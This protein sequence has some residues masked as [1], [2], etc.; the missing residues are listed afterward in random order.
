MKIVLLL[1][2]F[3]TAL[4]FT[5]LGEDVK[6][7]QKMSDSG[8]VRYAESEST[9]IRPA[10]SAEGKIIGK[11]FVSKSGGTAAR[12]TKGLYGKSSSRLTKSGSIDKKAIV[13]IVKVPGKYPLPQSRP[14]MRQKN[15]AIVP[16]VLPVLLGTTVD[17]PNEDEIYHNIFSLSDTK[18]FDLGRY[19][20]GKSKSVTFNTLGTVKVFCDIHSQMGGVIL[21]LQ[22]PYF[23][24]VGIDGS[25][26]ISGVPPGNYEVAAWQES[27]GNKVQ[28]ITVGSGEQSVVDFSF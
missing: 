20:K 14:V 1:S 19:S 17:F 12:S 4:V 6:F 15:I 10:V 26:S 27:G 13:F 25:Y 23:T 11:V 9:E 2:S 24:T 16:H 28:K 18:T 8:L 7:F 3:A 21:V 22:N 5:V